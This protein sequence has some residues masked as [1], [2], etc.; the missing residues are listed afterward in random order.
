M[1]EIRNLLLDCRAALRRADRKFES[2]PLAE[3]LIV[4]IDAEAKRVGGGRSTGMQREATPHQAPAKPAQQAVLAVGGPAR[5]G[6]AVDPHRADGDDEEKSDRQIGYNHGHGA[7][8]CR[9]PDA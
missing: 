8:V 5:Q 6:N 4:G 9:L 2:T 3:V 1:I 7:L